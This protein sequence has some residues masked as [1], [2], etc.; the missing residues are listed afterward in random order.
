VRAVRGAVCPT[1]FQITLGG[2]TQAEEDTL[3]AQGKSETSHSRHVAAQN[4]SG[5]VCAVDFVALNADGSAN[6][7]AGTPE[8]GAYHDIGTA[9]V[10]AGA[11]LG[12]KVQW[13]GAAVGAWID[14]EISH[15]HDYDHVQLDPSQYP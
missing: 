7:N 4:K 6:W 14:G 15:F 8:A 1:D 5:R 3:V 2:R 10:G 12:I 11:A 9:I 13:G